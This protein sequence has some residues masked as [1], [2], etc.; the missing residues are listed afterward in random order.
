LSARS[1]LG[2]RLIR[3]I[4][5]FEQ[6]YSRHTR[7]HSS[8]SKRRR[9]A[10]NLPFS[11]TVKPR[12]FTVK[13]SDRFSERRK[14]TTRR[15]VEKLQINQQNVRTVKRDEPDDGLLRKL[16]LYRVFRLFAEPS[17]YVCHWIAFTTWRRSELCRDWLIKII[18]KGP[19]ETRQRVTRL[20]TVDERLQCAVF[21]VT[22]L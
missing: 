19:V 10:M 21:A 11:T 1:E 17:S 13:N 15:R 8:R 6:F 12:L 3:M 18:F 5:M 7:G 4:S 2:A 16:D 20:Y 14:P 9:H 22:A